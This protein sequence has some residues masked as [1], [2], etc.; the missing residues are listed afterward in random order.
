MIWCRPCEPG[1]LR[2]AIELVARIAPAMTPPCAS[3]S[4]GTR[5][6]W[7]CGSVQVLPAADVEDVLQ[8]TFLT[9]WRSARR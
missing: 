2:D 9:A 7:L 4:A 1:R 8:E 6:G 5:R 3:C